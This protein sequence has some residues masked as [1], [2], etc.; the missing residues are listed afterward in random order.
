MQHLGYSSPTPAEVYGIPQRITVKGKSVV[1][2]AS[3]RCGRCD[4]SQ[5]V[6]NLVSV[7][8]VGRR[9]D[10]HAGPII[11][12]PQY[13]RKPGKKLPN[14]PSGTR[15]TPGSGRPGSE[16]SQPPKS[17]RYKAENDSKMCPD[18]TPGL[19][20]VPF[21]PGLDPAS[22]RFRCQ[23]TVKIRQPETRYPKCDPGRSG[24]Q[25]GLAAEK[26]SN[27]RPPNRRIKIGPNTPRLAV[28][29]AR[30]RA[31]TVGL[32]PQLTHTRNNAPRASRE[33]IKESR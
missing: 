14:T 26:E 18:P 4:P 27:I 8:L 12:G 5:A 17:D 28:G 31:A 13:R 20:R 29:R 19:R 30:A 24:F 32:N 23:K 7:D 21:G 2:I 22:M 9:P 6:Y 10:S 33:T 11:Y 3:G 1:Y 16:P 15:T 25:S